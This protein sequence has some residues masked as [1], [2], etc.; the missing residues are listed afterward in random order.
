MLN[1]PM[2]ACWGHADMNLTQARESLRGE[3]ANVQ[4]ALSDLGTAAKC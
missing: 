2:S 1:Q 4:A 3:A